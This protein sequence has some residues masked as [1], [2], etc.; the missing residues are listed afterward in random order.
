MGNSGDILPIHYNRKLIALVLG[1]NMRYCAARLVMRHIRGG[2]PWE[3]RPVVMRSAIQHIG[4]GV[5]CA[6]KLGGSVSWGV[7]EN[8]WYEGVVLRSLKHL[9]RHL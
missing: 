9:K 3:F 8:E 2:F 7:I 6:R 1:G 5:R 4:P